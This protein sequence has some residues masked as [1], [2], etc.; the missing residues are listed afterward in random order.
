MMDKEKTFPIS[1][2][3]Q[4]TGNVAVP[5]IFPISDK[6]TIINTI[7]TRTIEIKGQLLIMYLK[8]IFDNFQRVF[9]FCKNEKS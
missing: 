5:K 9:K 7:P 6:P 4:V 2:I 3:F 1:N 8:S